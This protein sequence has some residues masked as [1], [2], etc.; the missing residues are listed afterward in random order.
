M[1][2]PQFFTEPIDGGYKYTLT[3][4]IGAM[5]TEIEALFGPRDLNWTLLGFEFSEDGPQ[6]WYPGNH[7]HIVIQISPD[8]LGDDIRAYYQLAHECV[9]LLAPLRGAHATVFEEGI[10]TMYSQDYIY[11]LFGRTNFT[12]DEKYINAASATRELLRLS[13]DSIRTLRNVQP[14]F[15]EMTATTFET[16]GLK[17]IPLSLRETLLATF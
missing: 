12:Q 15:N 11:K 4:R 9:H 13:P 17:N 8:C 7:S 2:T 5:L 3:T 6:I 16:A 1:L 14:R 10:A